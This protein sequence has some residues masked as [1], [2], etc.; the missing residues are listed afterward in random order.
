MRPFCK[1]TECEGREFFNHAYLPGGRNEDFSI[2]QAFGP[3]FW[4]LSHQ[5]FYYLCLPAKLAIPEP[6]IIFD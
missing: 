6:S 2:F 4:S 3:F 1:L 5:C